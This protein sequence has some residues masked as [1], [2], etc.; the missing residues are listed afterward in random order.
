[1]LPAQIGVSF[2]Y[3]SGATF[4]T[5][6]VIGDIQNGI[7][8][9]SR[10]GSS[11][12]VTPVVDLTPDV[13]S[14]KINR[15]RNIMK[16]TFEAGTATVRVYDPDSNFSPQNVDSIYYP[17]LTPLRKIR[18]SATVGTDED[19]LFSGYVTDYKYFYDQEQN[20]AFVDLVC[21]DAFRLFQM[22]NV[23]TIAA[24]SSGQTTGERIEAIF[25]E[26]QFPASM[27]NISLGD[28]TVQADPATVRTTLAAIKNVEFSEQGAF[29]MDGWGTAVFKSR[30]EVVSAIAGTPK[31]FN[32][33][34]GIP[35]QNLK[36]SYDD[37]LI[38]NE[39]NFSR[40][41]GANIQIYSQE[42][43][44]K[45][46]PH[47]LTQSDLVA[48]TDEQVENIAREYVSTR[49]HTTIRIDEMV[50]D[51]LDPNVPTNDIIDMEFFDNL[52]IANIQPNGSEI[53]KVLQCQGISWEI[54]P[55][56]MMATI[57]TLE[58]ICDG[59]I[60]G[61]TFGY[62]TIGVSTMSY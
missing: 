18:I 37:K 20:M 56:K 36:F 30:G 22:A 40:V 41:G 46:F 12:V 3:S 33:T 29:Y 60:L 48:E 10:L 4:G 1:M 2:D 6:F 11:N 45:Y 25:D 34:G 39:V 17:Y 61:N 58:P 23:S 47:S 21:S 43:I 51:L 31:E 59:F 19:F 15:G 24:T 52:R 38:I 42:S 49:E 28:S 27:R 8:G 57:T 44:D 62:G 53:V 14:I 9:V 50:I 55:K 54:T 32:Q 13:Y 26:T 7:I 5:G 16:D 35:Y